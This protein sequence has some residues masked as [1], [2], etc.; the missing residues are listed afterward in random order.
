[1]KFIKAMRPDNIVFVKVG[2]LYNSDHVIK[3]KNNLLNF[4]PDSTYWCYTDNPIDNINNIN[5]I[6]T[7]KKWWPKLALFSKKMPFE[8]TVLYF[9]LDV[10]VN[11][12]ID[13]TSFQGLSVLNA[14][15]KDISSQAPHSYDVNINSSV[16]KW[17]SNYQDYIWQH[18]LS[19]KDYFMRKYVGIDRFLFHEKIKFYRF[20]EGVVN[21][22]FINDR[23]A[24]VDIYNGMKYE[25]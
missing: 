21:T 4:Y 3:L 22:M 25:P 9:D 12:K 8:G 18:F 10:V 11:K 23:E 15:W 14:Y 17:T 5:P 6:I 24:C 20:D 7:L 2:K 13:I 16:M 19:N 1:M